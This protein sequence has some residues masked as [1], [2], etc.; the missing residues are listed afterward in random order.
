MDAI[1]NAA[2][3]TPWWVYFLFIYLMFIGYKSS[4]TGVVPLGKLYVLPAIFLAMSV[5]TLISNFNITPFVFGI[6]FV[7]ILLGAGLGWLQTQ[8]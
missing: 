8:N 2:I 5:E 1:W 4:K 3:H 7:S 6:W